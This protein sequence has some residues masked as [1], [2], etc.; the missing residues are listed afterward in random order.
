MT[1][2][3]L[4]GVVGVLECLHK[5]QGLRPNLS[6]ERLSFAVNSLETVRRQNSSLI[7]SSCSLNDLLKAPEDTELCHHCFETRSLNLGNRL[8]VKS[9]DCKNGVSYGGLH[10]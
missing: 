7:D 2:G 8:K 3:T 9:M 4:K 5:S 6:Q 1:D 10:K